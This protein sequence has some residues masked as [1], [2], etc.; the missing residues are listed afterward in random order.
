LQG[1][2]SISG[3]LYN[4]QTENVILDHYPV[5]SIRDIKDGFFDLGPWDNKDLTIQGKA[6]SLH[7]IEHGVVRVLWKDTP[8]IHY[9]LN[10]AA[11]GCPNL[12]SV[13]FDGNNIEEIMQQAAY[14]Y[15]NSQRGVVVFNDGSVAISKIYSWYINDF[16]GSETEIL[17][18]LEQYASDELKAQ[19]SLRPIV[20]EYFYDW[21]LNDVRRSN[22]LSMPVFNKAMFN[23]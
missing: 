8:E 20:R 12:S 17:N 19:L 6:M 16:G 9:V 5:D 7:D 13:A 14:E 2:D 11:A 22:V 23:E 21:S 18:H 3:D 4:A 15:V 10:C 1:I